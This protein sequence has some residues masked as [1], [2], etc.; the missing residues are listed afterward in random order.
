MVCDGHDIARH[1]TIDIQIYRI[2]PIKRP[3]PNKARIH[4]F[5]IIPQVGHIKRPP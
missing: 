5:S 1:N 3:C 4:V 2:I